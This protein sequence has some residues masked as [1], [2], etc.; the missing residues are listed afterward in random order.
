VQTSGHRKAATTGKLRF[1]ITKPAGLVPTNF[2]LSMD[3]KKIRQHVSG[4]C[5]TAGKQ[6]ALS[7]RCSALRRSVVNFDLQQ[8]NASKH[9]FTQG[10][11]GSVVISVDRD[12]SGYRLTFSD[13][14]KGLAESVDLTDRAG[15]GSRI[16]AG[17]A[18]QLGGTM[19][20]RSN[21]GNTVEISMPANG[22]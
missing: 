21:P 13:D 1:T 19:Q 3:R 11:P 5:K 14:G 8:L 7:Y 16:M 2:E 6:L 4:K 18:G 15:L 20:V 10:E 22:S 17:L 9:A 12:P